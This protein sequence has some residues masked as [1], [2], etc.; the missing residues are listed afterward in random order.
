MKSPIK[1]D[2][3]PG[4]GEAILRGQVKTLLQKIEEESELAAKIPSFPRLVPP[5][6]SI[7]GFERSPLQILAPTP[8]NTPHIPGAGAGE[9]VQEDFL[10][11]PPQVSM[12]YFYSTYL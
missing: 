12:L 10:H 9:V 2:L 1:I 11:P 4:S 6:R 5:S 7:L 3:T 8:N